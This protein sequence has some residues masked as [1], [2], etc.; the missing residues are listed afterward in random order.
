MPRGGLRQR[1]R[2]LWRLHDAVNPACPGLEDTRGM[3]VREG[4]PAKPSLWT[5]TPLR[6]KASLGKAIYAQAA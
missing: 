4:L 5:A 6:D 3:R 1:R 2:R